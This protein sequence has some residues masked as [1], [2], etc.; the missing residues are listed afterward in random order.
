MVRAL[1]SEST[2]AEILNW[3]ERVCSLDTE[4]NVP[5]ET[6]SRC[7]K[8]KNRSKYLVP[9]CYCCFSFLFLFKVMKTLKMF[10]EKRQTIVYHLCVCVSGCVSVCASVC[11]SVCLS[12]C[13]SAPPTAQGH[14]RAFTS[15]N[16]TKLHKTHLT[17]N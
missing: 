6:V 3:L 4:A 2:S 7:Q 8:K 14:L 15:S 9:D 17:Q 13:L 5:G 16:L 1:S 11:A 10:T 12:V